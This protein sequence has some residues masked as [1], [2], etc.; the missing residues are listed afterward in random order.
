MIEEFHESKNNHTSLNPDD[1]NWF[2]D[3]LAYVTVQEQTFHM[4]T[5]LIGGVFYLL[6]WTLTLTCFANCY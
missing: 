3:V 1:P 5:A 4:Q 2:Y 6:K